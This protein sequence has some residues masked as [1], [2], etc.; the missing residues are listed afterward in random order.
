MYNPSRGKKTIVDYY[1]EEY[2]YLDEA[3][4]E[5][6]RAYPQ[7]ASFLNIAQLGDR[8]PYVERLFEGF[9]FLM[10]R[11][12]QKL[13][14]E[15]PE[16]TQ[17]LLGLLWPHFLRP[18]P[19]LSILEFRPVRNRFLE[20][21]LVE[22]GTQ[23]ASQPVRDGHVCRFRTCYDVPVRP[24]ALAEA[25]LR[26]STE[27]TFRFRV[28]SG[29]D[30][31]GLFAAGSGD[32]YRRR[33][34]QSIRL[35]IHDVDP[36]MAS[37]LHLYLTRYAQEMVVRTSLGDL[38]RLRGQEA[39]EAVRAVGFSPEEALLP[40]TVHSF[41]GYRLL[42]EYFA[43]PRKFLFFDLFGFG[44]LHPSG[45]VEGLDVQLT[46]EKPFPLYAPCTE[47]NFRLHCTPV[48][49]L[50]D[51]DGHPRA[52]GHE[53]TEYRVN[54]PRGCEVYSVNKVESIVSSTLER[55]TYMPFYSF[56]HSGDARYYSVRTELATRPN[57]EG[58]P[59]LYQ[60]TYLSIM[61]PDADMDGL[62]RE[63]LSIGITCTDGSSAR[64]LREGDICNPTTDMALPEFVQFGNLMQPT[65]PLYPPLETGFEWRFISHLA[66]NYLSLNHAEALREILELYDWSV[67]IGTREANRLR[68]AGIRDVRAR[69]LDV[70]HRGAIVRGIDVTCAIAMGNFGDDEG[71]VHLFGQ[72][73][74][75]FLSLY[76]SINSFVQMTFMA[77]D[78]QEEIFTWAPEVMTE[79]NRGS[80]MRRRHLPL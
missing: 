12:H 49:N 34:R 37:M 65:M 2:R 67:G 23:V 8:D 9:A 66:L 78:S 29:V 70:I 41:S 33:C 5:F 16:L 1:D 47:D 58:E 72:V 75:E 61:V 3:G 13:D 28:G 62:T 48:V 32:E 11:V 76:V 77:H 69:P 38:L 40:Y 15:L 6:A 79:G 20:P 4:R 74:R 45:E 19:S 10:G 68:V 73:I 52:V 54:A 25:G 43:Y 55:R 22:R 21:D 63:T 50:A 56:R 24:I 14:D 57:D 64:A 35:F 26:S 60:D 17:S 80:L 42:Q 36:R 27:I 71:D 46:F 44:R 59:E 7:R 31:S 53:A 51:A 18:V 30:Y 39:Q